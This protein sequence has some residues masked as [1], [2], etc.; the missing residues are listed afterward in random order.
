MEACRPATLPQRG[1]ADRDRAIEGNRVS[2]ILSA[3]EAQLR[4][5]QGEYVRPDSASTPGVKRQ[6]VL[7][8]TIRT[9]L[10]T[11]PFHGRAQPR[12]LTQSKR[13]YVYGDVDY[14]PREWP[15]PEVL[16]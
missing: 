7:E 11:D 3:L 1:L 10:V 4:D 15:W 8:T 14:F 6:G 2:D 9:S 13:G 5:H 16:R 12:A